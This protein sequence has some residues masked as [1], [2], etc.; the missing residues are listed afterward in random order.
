MPQARAISCTE[1]PTPTSEISRPTTSRISSRRC[2]P[3]VTAS[4]P[5]L[6]AIASTPGQTLAAVL[7]PAE[8]EHS[9]S[10]GARVVR[11]RCQGGTR[12]RRMRNEDPFF[13]ERYGPWAVVAGA[14]DGVGAAFA[15]AMA[16]R[17]INV[18]LLARRLSLLDEVAE[19][20][21]AASGVEVRTASIDL[22]ADDALAQVST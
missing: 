21:R 18:V 10:V 15:H 11:A 5:W 9:V 12:G 19:G 2:H 17:G 7:A 20:I 6:V 8:T 16:E 4:A 3:D 13:A 1:A 22:A 14:S